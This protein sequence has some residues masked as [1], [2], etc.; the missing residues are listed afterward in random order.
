M[1]ALIQ[2]VTDARVEIEGKTYSAINEGLLV[3]IGFDSKDNKVQA[4][5]MINKLLSYRVFN[6]AKDKMNLSV[7]DINGDVMIVS[8]F[9]LSADTKSG[10]R[11]GFSTAKN[12]LEAE[13]LYNYFVNQISKSYKN[14]ASGKFGSN[15]NISLTND[16]PVTFILSC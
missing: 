2:R 5:K 12:P 16:G 1:K 4:D 3:F 14:I 6:D 10:N 9:T 11:P 7:Q 15:M 8:Q 13:T